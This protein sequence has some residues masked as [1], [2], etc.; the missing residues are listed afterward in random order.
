VVIDPD[1]PTGLMLKE[2]RIADRRRVHY[3]RHGSA[4]SRLT[5]VDIPAG[6][7][8]SSRIL[9][10]GAI[11]PALSAS[12]AAAVDEAIRRSRKA[13]V[14]VSFDANYRAKL[15]SA[16]DFT[17]YVHARLPSIGLLFVS[18]DEA[19]MLLGGSAQRDPIEAARALAGRG[20]EPWW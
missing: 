9:H 10:A 2:Q 17:D 4:G 3:Y 13:G 16:T 19:Q 5:P 6:L 1:A 18:V 8:E 14:T 12:A 20:R 7:I 15:W 11:T